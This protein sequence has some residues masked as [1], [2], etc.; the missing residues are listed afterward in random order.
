M[1]VWGNV[2]AFIVPEDSADDDTHMDSATVQ[3]VA[4]LLKRTAHCYAHMNGKDALEFAANALLKADREC[5]S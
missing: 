5:M 2:K 4:Y 3:M 1:K